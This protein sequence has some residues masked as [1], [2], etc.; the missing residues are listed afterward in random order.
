M[1]DQKEELLNQVV[2]ENHASIYRICGDYL[3]D[4]SIAD[5]LYQEILFQIW[6]P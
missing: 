2:P 4:A 5:D 3:Y 6:K 1:I